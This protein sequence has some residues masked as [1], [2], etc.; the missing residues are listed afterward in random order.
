[1][2]M[3]VMETYPILSASDPHIHPV[4]RTREIQ[5]PVSSCKFI[6]YSLLGEPQQST[7]VRIR[8]LEGNLEVRHESW[9]RWRREVSPLGQWCRS[10]LTQ[11]WFSFIPIRK[12][13]SLLFLGSGFLFSWHVRFKTHSSAAWPGVCR[14]CR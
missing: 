5:V 8:Q 12:N 2:Q 14:V 13:I 1:M 9:E 11:L 10:C 4:R 7:H 6:A 3:P